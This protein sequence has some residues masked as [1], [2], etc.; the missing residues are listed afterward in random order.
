MTK[1]ELLSTVGHRPWS[2]PDG[3]WRFYQE[4]NKAIFLHWAVDEEKLRKL[5]PADLQIDLYNGT[6]WIS[7]V[8]FT[9]E[10]IRPRILPAFSPISNFDEI[11]I[12]TYVK[13]ADK[14]GVYFLSIE[15]G[16]KLSAWIAKSLSELPYRHSL[17]SRN[18]TQYQSFNQKLGDHLSIDFS[19]QGDIG[20]KSDLDIWLTERYAL[21]Q[22]AG[23]GI[24]KFEI[25]HLEWP[26]DKI[27]I[28]HLDVNYPRFA[29][30]FGGSP[31]LAHYSDGVRVLAWGKEEMATT[32]S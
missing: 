19:R 5:I 20:S 12:R 8:A 13:S 6:A 15:A 28:N 10:N 4:W 2:V 7:L 27:Q 18:Q 23:T 3:Q 25:H 32:Q 11:N 26:I 9:M 31:E 21:F 29:D 1:K 30:L 17:I 24:N 16:K 14:T 22:D